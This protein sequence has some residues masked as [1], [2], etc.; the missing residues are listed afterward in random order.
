MGKGG[1]IRTVESRKGGGRPRDGMS[2][3]EVKKMRYMD[4]SGVMR[5]DNYCT[6][7]DDMDK[8]TWMVNDLIE[9]LMDLNMEAKPE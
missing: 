8:L 9:E 6:I 3:S 4:S 1:Q 2:C 7:S 5:V